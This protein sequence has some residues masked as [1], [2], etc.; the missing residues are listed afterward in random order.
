MYEEKRKRGDRMHPRLM[1]LMLFIHT[2]SNAHTIVSFILSFNSRHCT[3]NIS[4]LELHL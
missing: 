3:V 4:E 2:H 1:L